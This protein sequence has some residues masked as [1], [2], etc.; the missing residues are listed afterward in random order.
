MARHCS[1]AT[2][3]GA[4]SGSYGDLAAATTACPQVLSVQGVAAWNLA[5]YAR[6]AVFAPVNT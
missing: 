3:V 4:S 5:R 6:D 2:F 1:T